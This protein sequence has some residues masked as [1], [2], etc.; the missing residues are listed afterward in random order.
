MA[1]PFVA[2]IRMFACNFAPRAWSQCNGQLLPIAQNTALFAL[3]GTFYGGNG[4]SNFALPNL[5][6]AAP[7]HWGN[8]AG[9][10]P[11]DI[12]Q[13]GGSGSVV[14]LQTEI[15]QHTHGITVAEA[16]TSTNVPSGAT[17]LGE[18]SPSKIFIPTGTLAATFSPSA[19]GVGGGS[20]PHENTQPYV[21]MNFCIAL[22]GVFPTRN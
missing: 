8:G 5:Q 6:G 1:N 11:Y 17:W 12:G 3:I 19:I 2:E 18:A 10:S 9:L 22:Q 21:T 20:Q 7:M 13:T 15:P 16:G 14:L 4:T